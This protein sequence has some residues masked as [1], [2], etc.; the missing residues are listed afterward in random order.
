MVPKTKKASPPKRGEQAI[1]DTDAKFHIMAEGAA[2]GIFIL[3]GT[4]F[5]YVNLAAEH[6]TGYS[7]K[8]LLAMNYTNLVPAG[9]ASTLRRLNTRLQRGDIQSSREEFKLV[10]KQGEERWIDLTSGPIEYN[11]RPAVMGTA[12]DVTERKRAELLQDAVYRIAQATDRSKG[13]DDLLPALHAIIS[14]VVTARNFYIALY[15]K[16]KDLISFPYY[17]DEY[18]HPVGSIKPEKGLTDYILRTGKSLLCD[19]ET[20]RML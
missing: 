6:L 13:L 3:Q 5:R 9:L 8:E 12:S 20:H 17:V 14:E 19:L 10:T 15:D 18:D 1:A 11:G 4:H 7:R 2:S 16:E